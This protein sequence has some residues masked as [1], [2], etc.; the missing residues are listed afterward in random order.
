MKIAL[1]ISGKVRTLFYGFH[2]N[3]EMLRDRYP[4]CEIDVF[5]SFWDARDRV[6]RIND[7]WHFRPKNY[8]VPEVT[9]KTIDS[10]FNSFNVKSI[11]EVET[12][13]KMNKIMELSP[14][15]QKG[16]SSQYYKMQR[17]VD[18][19]FKSGYD[20][21]FRI[22]SDILIHDSPPVTFFRDDEVAINRDYWYC[23]PYDGINCNEM[24]LVSTEKNFEII[25]RAYSDQDR[26][27]KLKEK[28]GEFITGNYLRSLNLNLKTF[29]FHY[30]VVR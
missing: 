17:V 15:D 23:Q 12:S 11:G 13:E 9:K 7:G 19:Y 4:E 22:R 24:I 2:K 25:N 29:N 6:E 8:E 20:L 28:Y 5:Y 26:L 21:Y 16:L 10:Y 1:Y 27:S 14:F 18:Q 30:R 3:I